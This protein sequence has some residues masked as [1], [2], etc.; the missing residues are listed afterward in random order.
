DVVLH[1]N[2]DLDEMRSVLGAVPLLSGAAAERW[3]RAEA[4]RHAPEPADIAALTNR[5]AELLGTA[6]A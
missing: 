3:A 5:L 2:G 1:C 6:Q 4:M